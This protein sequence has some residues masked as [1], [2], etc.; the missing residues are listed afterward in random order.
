LFGIFTLNR[1]HDSEVTNANIRLEACIR[2]FW[3]LLSHKGSEFRIVDN[4]LQVDGHV[5]NGDFELPDR[6]QDIFGGV[7]TIFM[8]DERVSTNVL[9]ARG[10]RAVGTRLVGPA[11]DSVFNLKKPYR[12]TTTILGFPY[13]TAYDPISDREGRI[14]GALFVGIKESDF[15]AN[16]HAMKTQMTL[17]MFILVS[18]L[19]FLMVLLGLSMKRVEE[20]NENQLKF[21]NT[22]LNT[23]PSPIF[24][25]DSSCRYLGCNKAFEEY[26][27][28]TSEELIGKSPHDLWPRELADSYRDQDL[29]MFSNPGM[30]SYETTARYADGTLRDVIFNKA[31]FSG[32]DGSVAGLV[33]VIL[34]ITERK[35]TE[36]ALA[37]QNILLSTQTEA[38][39]DGILVVDDNSK[40]LS[41]NKHFIDLMAIPPQLLENM[42][43]GPVLQYVTGRMA[44]PQGFIEKVKYLYE[45]RQENSRD[46]IS[47]I[48][49]KTLD[50]FTV[51][52]LGFD[53]HYYGR[54]WSFR[55]ITEHTAAAEE[56]KSAYQQLSDIIEF[57]PDATFVTDKN[58]R[59]IAWNQA[60]EKM[61][62]V[63]K[64]DILGKGDYAYAIPFYNDNRP[65]LI[66]LLGEEQ[67]QERKRLNYTHIKQEGRTLF[68]EV[69]V[70]S[71]RNGVSRYFWATATPLFGKDGRQ[72]G[73]IESIRDITEYRR[74]ED[75]KIRLQS[76]LAYSRL[77]ETI[78]I[79]LGHD[80]KTPLT[81]LFILLPLLK[82][83]LADPAHIKH[84]ET[85]M[86]SAASIKNLADKTRTLARLSSCSE[87]Q[88]REDV[89]LAA[90]VDESIADL[91]DTLSQN[92]QGCQ[93]SVNPSIMVHGVQEQLRELLNNLLS[94]SIHFSD[95]QGMTTISAE[96]QDGF[97]LVSVQDQGS[98]IAVSHL[99][100]VF[101]EFYKTDESRHNLDTSGLGLSICKRIVQNHSGR[102]WAESPGSGRGT[103]INFTIARVRTH[104]NHTVKETL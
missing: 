59:V 82:K 16:M 69:F 15:L 52:L 31:T 25:K 7:A 65:L 23:I 33:G 13:L 60:I 34:D 54:L 93:N 43:D 8:N 41:Y 20:N 61:T 97:V 40:I 14:I 53:G 2:T 29:A 42:E 87:E 57:L 19:T 100:H 74:A 75:E 48:D 5:L 83:Q 62:G 73:G 89:S 21:Q 1:Y 4:K 94:N 103:T 38:S 46:E 30:N 84:L 27:G 96:E 32:K 81:P 98:G 11:H 26:V 64:G 67:E 24:Y 66:D 70:P 17:T 37:F 6:I 68:T 45:H 63:P 92:R 80:L 88:R 95:A 72:A 78:M 76:Q 35:R 85:C 9:N 28:F 18:V 56:I 49:G 90:L 104:N 77:M 36:D 71:F 39:I 86:K 102:I 50:R 10:E 22:L 99:E 51:P 47:L 58:K 91:K 55:D 12:G 79:R 44:D 101:D 3:Q